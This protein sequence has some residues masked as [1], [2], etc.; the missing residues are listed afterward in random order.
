M[1]CSRSIGW[2]F[3]RSALLAGAAAVT[4]SGEA[5]AGSGANFVT[6][7]HHVAEKGEIEVETFSDFSNVGKGGE[8]YSAQLIELE[9]GVTDQLTSAFYL[10]G[11]KIEGEGYAFGGSPVRE[12]LS[13]I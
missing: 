12:P 7:N 10:E 4:L 8:D 6:Y 11:D 9:I 13:R 3:W 1:K 2:V 5:S